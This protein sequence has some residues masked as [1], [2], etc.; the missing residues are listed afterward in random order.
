M[1]N[2]GQNLSAKNVK[3]TKID[4]ISQLYAMG[5]MTTLSFFQRQ[6]A[7]VN[8]RNRQFMNIL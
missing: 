2:K 8:F 7:T 5:E 1:L 6:V 4:F 3:L